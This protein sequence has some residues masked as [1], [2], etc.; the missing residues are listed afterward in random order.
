MSDDNDP[1]PTRVLLEPRDGPRVE[2]ELEPGEAHELDFGLLG[3]L[4]VE[5]EGFW[6][7][8]P[9][10]PDDLRERLRNGQSQEE[11]AD[12][13]GVSVSTVSRWIDRADAKPSHWPTR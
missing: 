3:T 11:I 2:I 13:L 8:R 10:D 1:Y 7:D 12:D 5:N 6:G 9:T 4:R